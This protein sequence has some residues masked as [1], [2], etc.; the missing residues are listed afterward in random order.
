MR[1]STNILTKH[2]S[3][4]IVLQQYASHTG[5]N[6][7]NVMSKAV[8]CSTKLLNPSCRI[9]KLNGTMDPPPNDQ[10]NPIE[11]ST[12]EIPKTHVFVSYP[13]CLPFFIHYSDTA[14]PCMQYVPLS[15]F[16]S[17]YWNWLDVPDLLGVLNNC[18]VRA[19]ETCVAHND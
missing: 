7:I 16:S 19:E 13:T 8:V 6:I 9:K 12:Q 14:G 1:L 11:N 4:N 3:E 15:L 18:S 5:C 17:C 2:I 10:C